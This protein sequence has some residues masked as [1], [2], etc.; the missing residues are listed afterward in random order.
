MVSIDF[1]LDEKF[2]YVAKIVGKQFVIGFTF[3]GKFKKFKQKLQE[4]QTLTN[5]L[6]SIR[7]SLNIIRFNYKAAI[8]TT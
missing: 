7:K 1:L 8:S 5:A 2:A 6:L 4:I 3:L